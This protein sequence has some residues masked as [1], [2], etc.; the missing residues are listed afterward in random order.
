MNNV[1]ILDFGSQ[2]TQLIARRVRELDVFSE[3]LPWDIS[4]EKIKDLNP[5]GIILSGGP[6]SVTVSNT[7]R[8]PEIA[9]DLDVPILGICYG[10]QL[11]SHVFG[12][13]VQKSNKREY[14]LSALKIHGHQD[15]FKGINKSFNCWMSHGDKVVT[16]P[17][18]FEIMASTP[19]CAIAGMVNAAKNFYGVQFHPESILSEHGHALLKNFLQAK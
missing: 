13:K 1:L 5:A 18:G 2:Y 11:L 10:M 15:L 12:G 6:E 4:P 17:E 9:F 3:I 7:P 19:S 16:M 8:I 14:G